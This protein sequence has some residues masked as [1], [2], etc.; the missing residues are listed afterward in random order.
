MKE[1]YRQAYYYSSIRRCLL[2]TLVVFVFQYLIIMRLPFSYPALPWYP[3]MGLAVVWCYL[4]GSDAIFGLLLA[5]LCG[6]FLSGFSIGSVVLYCLADIACGY[7]GA[8]LC[9]N[10]FSSDIRIFKDL[11]EWWNFFIKN[12]CLVCVLSGGLRWL[13]F[14]FNQPTPVA[15][16]IFFY[17]Y[18]DLWLADLNSILLLSAFLFSW[19]T[20]PFS[21]EKMRAELFLTLILFGFSTCCLAYWSLYKTTVP[22]LVPG[23]LL[24]ITALV[25][26]V[27]Y[28]FDHSRISM[29]NAS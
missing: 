4:L 12:A 8:F 19:V 17:H 22:M 5:G 10:S 15:P 13:A 27:S 9:Q 11:K 14:W 3:P 7:W 24:L 1:K 25:I 23:A 18:I 29:G 20:I 6:Y 26:G 28:V 16:T 21:R 2:K